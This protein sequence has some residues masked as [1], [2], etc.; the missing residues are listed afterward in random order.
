MPTLSNSVLG[1]AA[2]IAGRA[3]SGPCRGCGGVALALV[4]DLGAQPPAERFVA[5]EELVS[6]DALLDLRILVCTTCWLVQLEGEPVP[7]GDEPGGLAF[8]VSPTM[9]AHVDGLVDDVLE[10]AGGAPG[11]SRGTPLRIVEVASHGNRLAERFHARGTLSTLV[12]AVPHFAADAEAAGVATVEARLT[13]EVAAAIVADSGPADAFVD[14]FYLAHDPRPAEYLAGVTGLLAHDGVAVFEFDHLLPIVLETQYDGFRHGHASYL[15]L[16]AFTRLLDNAG[17]VL[18]DAVMTPAYGGSVRA[19]VRL[20]GPSG[21]GHRARAILSAESRAGLEGLRAYAAFAERAD[22]ARA[23]LRA[24]LDE[25]RRAGDVVVAYG[26][27]SRGNTLLNSS[28]VTPADVPF[29][30]DR[31]ASKHGRYLPGSRIPIIPVEHVAKVRPAYLLILTWDLRDEVIEQMAGVR[32][33]GGRF[34]VP[35]PELTVVD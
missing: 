7:P 8:S 32:A 30:V 33:W 9:R 31:S 25:R 35:L 17:L 34:V 4:V 10:R 23:R 16:G 1:A 11:L 15:S 24:F 27:P 13:P 2:P 12:E 3:A 26:A 29:A 28:A 5:P 6:P 14:A 19:F 18:E 21:P 22:S 20:R